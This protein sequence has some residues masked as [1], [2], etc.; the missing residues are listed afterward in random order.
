MTAPDGL[1]WEYRYNDRYQ[2]VRYQYPDGNYRGYHYNERNQLI[3]VRDSR[4]G[5]TGYQR[6]LFNRITI[7]MQADGSQY[8]YEYS[9]VHVNQ[10]QMERHRKNRPPFRAGV[11]CIILISWFLWLLPRAR[12]IVTEVFRGQTKPHPFKRTGAC[13]RSAGLV[14]SWTGSLGTAPVF[15]SVR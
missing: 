2:V 12:L 1:K 9:Q 3:S 11:I 5:Q 15:F 10:K 4:G 13:V 7:L 8:R 6:D 14:A